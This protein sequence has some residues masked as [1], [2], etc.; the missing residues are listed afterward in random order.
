M[1]GAIGHLKGI[2]VVQ[3]RTPRYFTV[4][5]EQGGTVCAPCFFVESCDVS[6]NEESAAGFTPC[7]HMQVDA[8]GAQYWMHYERIEGEQNAQAQQ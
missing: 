1:I 3:V 2:P 6:S 5:A 7:H 4:R 8:E